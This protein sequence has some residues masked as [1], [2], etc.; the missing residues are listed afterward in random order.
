M[1]RF[2]TEKQCREY[3]ASMR[4]QAGFLCSKCGARHSYRLSNGLYQCT[5][6]HWQISVTAGTVLHRSHVRLTIWFLASHLVCYDKQGISAVHLARQIGVT[7]KTAWYTLKRIR[8]AMGQ[9]DTVHKLKGIVEFDD[10]YFGG[11]T[12]GKKRDRGTERVKVFVALSLDVQGNPRYLKMQITPNI[13]QMSVKKFAHA[14]FADGSVIRSDGYRSYIPAL[15]GYTHEHSPYDSNSGLLHCC[16]S[17]SVMPRHSSLALITACQK[18]ISS[19]IWTSSAFVSPAISSARHCWIVCPSPSCSQIRLT[20]R[21]NHIFLLSP[22]I[23]FKSYGC[24][25]NDHT[26]A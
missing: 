8:T 7:Y 15:E 20:Q 19:P 4:W 18:P 16:T 2:S 22:Q 24:S 14:A 23:A 6:C 26:S 10:A 13:K 25:G 12:T 9:R 5:K 11:P 3:L 17:S 1:K 21:D